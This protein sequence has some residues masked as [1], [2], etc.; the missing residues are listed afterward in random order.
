MSAPGLTCIARIYKE[1]NS[2]NACAC[3]VCRRLRPGTFPRDVP[4]LT[5]ES[6]LDGIGPQAPHA[7][8]ISATLQGKAA[9]TAHTCRAPGGPVQQ[10]QESRGLTA[11]ETP[12]QGGG[13]PPTCRTPGG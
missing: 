9:S 3:P 1:R 13:G 4:G 8:P 7:E 10:V 12:K 5:V 2:V 11:F 6:G